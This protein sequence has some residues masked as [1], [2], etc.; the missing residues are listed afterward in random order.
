MLL[1]VSGGYVMV[2]LAFLCQWIPRNRMLYWL[3]AEDGI[4]TC[5]FLVGVNGLMP[6]SIKDVFPV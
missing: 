3:L 2:L 1:C 4:G 5:G 6:F